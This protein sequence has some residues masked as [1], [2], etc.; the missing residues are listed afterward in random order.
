M[1]A[2]CHLDE[3][4]KLFLYGDLPYANC[5]KTDAVLE[6][7]CQY[8]FCYGRCDKLAMAAQYFA[9]AK[10]AVSEDGPGEKEVCI[11]GV[12]VIGEVPAVTSYI[13]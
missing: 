9:E 13:E 8:I 6:L 5:D 10:F 12:F 11:A 1:Q 7:L 2:I 4:P 3:R